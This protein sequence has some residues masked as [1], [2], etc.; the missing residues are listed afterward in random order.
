[1]KSSNLACC[2][3]K[4]LAAGLARLQRLR[5]A[6]VHPYRQ[7][8]EG[9]GFLGGGERIAAEQIAAGEVADG[10]RVAVAPVGEH[11][12]HGL[13]EDR[14]DGADSGRVDIGVNAPEAF[15]DLGSSPAGPLLLELHDEL[16][17]LER[18]LVGMALGPPAAVSQ[19]I[20]AA[21]LVAIED[22]VARFPG[23]IELPAQ[24]C[25]LLP[26]QQS[27]HEPK[28]FVH[29]VTLSFHG[30]LPSRKGQKCY[31]CPRNEVL[32]T[33]RVAQTGAGRC[34]AGIRLSAVAAELVR[35]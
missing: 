28:A 6:Q 19:P 10:E 13:V 32:P 4:F 29:S 26:I 17:D 21:V 2:C 33:C 16:F 8:R 7:R 11:D 22:L 14:M 35:L 27:S 3:R 20:Q 5:P 23:D 1:M 18:Q 25:H 34:V 9:I 15:P 12:R 30:T 31:L 24:R